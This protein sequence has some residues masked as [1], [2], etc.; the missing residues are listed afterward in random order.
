M[1]RMT[2][3]RRE[4]ARMLGCSVWSI[5]RLIFNGELGFFQVGEGEQRIHVRIPVA[6]I[7]RLLRGSQVPEWD[8]S[9][10]PN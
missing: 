8:G 1:D 10:P 7:K 9:C 2:V 6:D 3:T 4:A 5:D